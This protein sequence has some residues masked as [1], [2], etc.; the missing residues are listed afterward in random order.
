[1]IKEER[2]AAL[3]EIISGAQVRSQAQLVK[4]LRKKGYS[5]TQASVSRDLDEL[6]VT[7]DAGKYHRRNAVSQRTAFG[8]VSFAPSGSNLIIAK[9]S[10]GLASALA[11]RLD[12]LNLE[13]VAGSIAGDDTV[14][15]ALSAADEQKAVLAKLRKQ[16]SE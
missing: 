14:F 8:T 5:V 12:A 6:G 13:G 4:A 10:S 11:V 3:L 7:K 1:M 9:C 2:Q 16:F 15:V